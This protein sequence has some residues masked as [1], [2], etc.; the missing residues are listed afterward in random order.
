MKI[1]SY[2]P[3]RHAVSCAVFD[4][5]PGRCDCGANPTPLVTLAEA[6]KAVAAAQ[7]KEGAK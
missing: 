6:Q 2:L 4:P 7:N 5:T 1:V 3:A